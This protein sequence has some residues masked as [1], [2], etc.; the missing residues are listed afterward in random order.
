MGTPTTGRAAAV[1]SLTAR[2]YDGERGTET[3]TPTTGRAAT[4]STFTARPHDGGRSTAAGS[5]PT[6]GSRKVDLLGL[7]LPQLH[8][9]NV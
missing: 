2:S 1:S 8:L 4:V 6:T 5:A 3:G 9:S 7:T